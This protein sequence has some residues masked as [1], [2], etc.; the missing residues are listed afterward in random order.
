[1]CLLVQHKV[2]PTLK[3][4]THLRQDL[5]FLSL[6]LCIV[7]SITGAKSLKSTDGEVMYDEKSCVLVPHN[8]FPT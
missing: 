8:S 2:E 3:K 7:L 4:I 5:Q 1:M 6:S